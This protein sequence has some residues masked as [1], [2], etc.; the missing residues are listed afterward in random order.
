MH[1]FCYLKFTPS[2]NKAKGKKGKYNHLFRLYI[3]Y[4]DE[5]SQGQMPTNHNYDGVSNSQVAA[6]S[7]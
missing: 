7:Y 1:I 6:T 3:H 4:L 2:V 5:R